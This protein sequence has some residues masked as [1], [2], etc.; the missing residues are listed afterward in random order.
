MLMDT[1][2]QIIGNTYIQCRPTIPHNV[3]IVH[4][5]IVTLIDEDPRFREDDWWCWGIKKGLELG[6]SPCPRLIPNSRPLNFQAIYKKGLLGPSA[7]K[8]SFLSLE[9]L[10]STFDQS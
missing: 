2:N 9:P 4:I 6:T 7:S 10:R 5:L 3:H 8:E 1:A